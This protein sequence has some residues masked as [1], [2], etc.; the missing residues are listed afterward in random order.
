MILNT[1]Q[2]LVLTRL[3]AAI[4]TYGAINNTSLQ[5]KT[6]ETNNNAQWG[7]WT[8]RAEAAIDERSRRVAHRFK[9]SEP[10][11]PYYSEF[12]IDCIILSLFSSENVQTRPEKRA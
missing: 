10:H 7:N 2:F 5:L 4:S 6:T 11:Q 8:S 1:K 3:R 9:Q 12:D